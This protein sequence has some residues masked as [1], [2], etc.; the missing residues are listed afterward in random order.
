MHYIH[1]IL[2][3]LKRLNHIFHLAFCGDKRRIE[4]FT[5][6][7][8]WNE[9]APEKVDWEKFQ[10]EY[11]DYIDLAKLLQLLPVVGCVAGGT[12]NHNLLKKLKVTAMNCYRMR[13]LSDTLLK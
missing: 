13:I 1:L 10:L 9:Y 7:K 5:T 3:F 2:D 4:I 8:N 12:A 6:I 11:R